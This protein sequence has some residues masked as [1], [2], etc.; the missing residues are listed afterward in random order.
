MSTLLVTHRQ[1]DVESIIPGKRPRPRVLRR[2]GF[3]TSNNM[4]HGLWVG[5]SASTQDFLTVMYRIQALGFNAVRLPMSFQARS[6]C[7]LALD[8]STTHPEL[9]INSL[10][11]HMTWQIVF[12]LRSRILT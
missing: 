4:V 1:A 6:C 7:C 2:F 3:E 12:I 9:V 10:S 5:P 11:C 8:G